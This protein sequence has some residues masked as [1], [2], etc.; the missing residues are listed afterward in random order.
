MYFLV[1]FDHQDT[2]LIIFIVSILS[3]DVDAKLKYCCRENKS[4]T[5]LITESHTILTTKV[6]FHTRI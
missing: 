4:T 1:R 6:I 2:K 3:V 5:G